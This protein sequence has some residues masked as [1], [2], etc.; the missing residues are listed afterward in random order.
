MLYCS[1]YDQQGIVAVSIAGILADD[2]VHLYEAAEIESRIRYRA[3]APVVLTAGQWATVPVN[4]EETQPA[5][6]D[7][8]LNAQVIMQL[9]VGGV[10]RP[11]GRMGPVGPTGATG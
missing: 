11:A 1:I 5:G 9:H 4:W 3:T 2:L 6:F 8:M 10:A 7:P